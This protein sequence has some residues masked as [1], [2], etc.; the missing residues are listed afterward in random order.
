MSVPPAIAPHLGQDSSTMKM[1]WGVAVMLVLA[2]AS[3][4]ADD[5]HLEMMQDELL[6][7][8]YYPDYSNSSWYIKFSAKVEGE[9][10]VSVSE[11]WTMKEDYLELAALKIPYR[12]KYSRK[13][14]HMRI[15]IITAAKATSEVLK[16]SELLPATVDDIVEAYWNMADSLAKKTEDMGKNQ[17]RFAVMYHSVVISSA[18]R[19]MNGSKQTKDICLASPDYE[20]TES[21]SL[22][23]CMQD[24]QQFNELL[25]P[26]FNDS[27]GPDFNRSLVPHE[28]Q[29]RGFFRRVARGVARVARGVARVVR[30]TA[31][32]TVRIFRSIF[33]SPKS[34]DGTTCRIYKYPLGRGLCGRDHGCC[35]NYGGCCHFALAICEIHDYA[36]TCCKYWWCFWKCE[37]DASCSCCKC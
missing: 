33:R 12:N 5:L 18:L 10:I 16:L 14:D 22:F 6:G 25:R 28:R 34:C 31:R 1:A 3:V 23:I 13:I 8:E 37:C 7:G 21:T 32:S 4:R 36:C 15:K 30:I 17:V 19:I 2:A 24:L 35:S 9:D 29:R 26:D 20:Y 11:I 27:L